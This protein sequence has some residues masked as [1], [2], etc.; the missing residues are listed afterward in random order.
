MHNRVVDADRVRELVTQGE[1]ISC[2]FK[3]GRG[4]N[5]TDLVETATCMANGPGGVVIVERGRLYR[6]IAKAGVEPR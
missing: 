3:R 6:E 2:E 4:L 5:D 1:T